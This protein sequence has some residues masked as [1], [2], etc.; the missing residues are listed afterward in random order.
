MKMTLS[1]IVMLQSLKLLKANWVKDCGLLG[2]EAV[3]FD[4]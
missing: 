3:E 4:R 2:Y 1:S